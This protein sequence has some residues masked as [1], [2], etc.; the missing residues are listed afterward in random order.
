MQGKAES[1]RKLLSLGVA[2]D[3]RNKQGL[4]PLVMAAAC[5]C[6]SA[7]AD[8]VRAG[9]DAGLVLSGGLTV[10]HI[11]ADMGLTEVS[12]FERTEM[13]VSSLRPVPSVQRGSVLIFG[14]G[15]VLG[16]FL[17]AVEALLATEVGRKC[18][19]LRDEKDRV[20]AHLAAMSGRR[21]LVELLLRHA[22]LGPDVTLEDVTARG[23]VREHQTMS[24]PGMSSGSDAPHAQQCTHA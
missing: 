13:F 8:L 21:H 11:S 15:R 19:A 10:L 24:L 16:T 22:D 20:P 23:K 3:P 17:K 14:R 6:G 1:V 5:G 2:P 18:A 12:S 9:A 7:V 4:S